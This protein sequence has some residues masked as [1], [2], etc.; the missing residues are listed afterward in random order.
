MYDSDKDPEYSQ[1][2]KIVTATPD[3]FLSKNVNITMI[4]S[5][6]GKIMVENIS[7]P[8][9]LQCFS[10]P[11]TSQCTPQTAA[12]VKRSLFLSEPPTKR[13]VSDITAVSTSNAKINKQKENFLMPPEDFQKFVISALTKI[14]YDIAGLTHTVNASHLIL[15]SNQN[16]SSSLSHTFQETFVLDEIFPIKTNYELEDFEKKI[17]NDKQFRFNIISKLSLM[18]G[19]KNVGDS[20]RRLMAKMFDD[21][22]LV[23]YSLQ[24]FKKKKRFQKL[25]TYRLLIDAIRI[26]R[27]FST[28]I[29]SFS[30]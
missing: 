3:K 20:V 11:S 4:N 7:S 29:D 30:V 2:T 17:E 27:K 26:H 25:G 23:E 24:G 18:V 14:K 15:D 1:P 16:N 9:S 10:Q 8:H 6:I 5:P 13:F 22:I 28:L 12:T 19:I 21:D